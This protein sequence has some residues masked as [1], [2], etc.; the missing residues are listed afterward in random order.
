MRFG[1]AL[2]AAL[3]VGGLLAGPLAS[4]ASADGGLVG[5]AAPSVRSPIASDTFYFVMTDRYRD[6][7]PSN[8]SGGVTGGVERTGYL[9]ESEAY[10]HGGDLKGL[11]GRCDPNDPSDE[12][13]ARLKRLG[14]TAVWITPPFVQRTVQGSSAAYHGY[15][16]LDITRPDP[17]LGD[18]ADFAAFMSCAKSL[19][20]KVFLDV[21]VNHTADVIAYPQ[22]T[23]YVSLARKPYRTAAGRAF[24]PWDFTS[25]RSFPRLSPTRSFAKTPTVPAALKDA[26]RPA[27]LNEVTR[28]HNRGDIDWGSCVGRCETDGDFSGLDDLMTEDWTVVK[29]LADAYGEWITKYGVDGFRID[30][31][32]HVDPYFFGRWLP[33]IQATAASSGKPAFTE[34]AEAWMQDS[35]QL[36]EFQQTRGLPSVLDFPFQDAVRQF[37]T[38]RAAGGL[39]TALF[40]EDDYYTSPS[41]NAYGLTTFLGN[42]DMGR[43]GFFLRTQS[44]DQGTDL[45]QRD[46]LA[47]DVLYL[48]RGVPIVY[49]GDEVGMTGSGDGTDKQARQDMFPTKVTMWQSEERIGGAPIGTGSSFDRSTALEAHLATLARLRAEHPALAT[50]A[51]IPR[52]SSGPVFA[53]SRIDAA[54]RKE[55]VVAFNGGADAAS[56]D[57]RASTPGLGW[58]PLLGEGSVSPG[59]GGSLRVAVPA[60]ST[61][62][63]E[64]DQPLPQPGAPQ[65]SLRTGKDAVTGR[66]RLA[67]TVPGNDPSSVTFLVR[68]PGRA[69]TVAGTDDARPFRVFLPTGRGSVQVAAV[70]EDSAGRRAA[71]APRTL[72]ITPFL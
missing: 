35:A 11:T 10:F 24:D 53:V 41:T 43:I 66:Y 54:Q 6:G 23:A 14:F 9:P 4:G 57:V 22:G 39:M 26:K 60:R 72:R 38:G 27:V 1:R 17:H 48:T 28:Y 32:K 59:A 37:A 18:E 45:E 40:G 21:V 64:A 13:L 63:L 3:A 68:R 65:V 25:G 19:G 34:F 33:M 52:G 71:T 8:N 12:G 61:V 36:A 2:L 29:A 51:M 50:G 16:F 20:I 42:H 58:T 7:D 69:W 46:L 55:Y 15:W 44:Q 56:I 47:H 67:A 49:Y 30:T 31:A 5:L 70:V 62:V